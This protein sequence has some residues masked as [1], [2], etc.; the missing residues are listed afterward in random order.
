MSRRVGA[1]IGLGLAMLA[2]PALAGPPFITDDPEPVDLG[3]WEVYGFSAGSHVR[4]DTG[5][6]LGGIEVNNGAAPNLQLHLIVPLAFDKPTGGPFV[7]GL[8]DT[9]LGMKY[10]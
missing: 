3:H 9:E 1:L 5:G 8:A 6:T 7:T 2:H 10:R 4:G